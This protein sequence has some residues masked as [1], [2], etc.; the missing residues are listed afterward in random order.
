MLLAIATLL[1]NLLTRVHLLNGMTYASMLLKVSKGVYRVL[2]GWVHLCPSK[3][4]LL[5]SLNLDVPLEHYVLKKIL[6]ARRRLS[7]T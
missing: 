2:K 7:I 5:A 3:P 4:I 6:E 1:A